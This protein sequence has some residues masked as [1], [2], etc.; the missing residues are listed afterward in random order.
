MKKYCLENEKVIRD[1]LEVKRFK[2]AESTISQITNAIEKYQEFTDYKNFKIFNIKI[3]NSY[4]RHLRDSNLSTSTIN[5]NLTH[6]RKFFEWLA[7]QVDSF[8]SEVQN[9]EKIMINSLKKF[10]KW[11]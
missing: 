8:M 4:V 6:L 1:Y 3:V 9:L 10:Q 11:H 2:F 7:P 5:S